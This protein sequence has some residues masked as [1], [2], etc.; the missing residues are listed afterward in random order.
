MLPGQLTFLMDTFGEAKESKYGYLLFDLLPH[1]DPQY[2][3]RLRILLGQLTIVYLPENTKNMNDLIIKESCF[4]RL[5]LD[6]NDEQRKAMVETITQR[7]LKAVAQI[8][9]NI[10]Q[11]ARECQN[12]NMVK[13]M[14]EREKARDLKDPPHQEGGQDVSQIYPVNTSGINESYEDGRDGSQSKTKPNENI[15]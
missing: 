15:T 4:L 2:K 8:A 3:L 13:S 9:S 12:E 5:L 1:S 14:T 6:T 7:Q 11:R 10:H